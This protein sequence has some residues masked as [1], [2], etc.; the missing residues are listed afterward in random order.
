MKLSVIIPVRNRADH[1]NRALGALADQRGIAPTDVEVILSDD[2]STDAL[3]DVVARHRDRLDVRVVGPAV[4][5]GPFR[6]GAIRNRGL[7]A[8]KGDVAVLLDADVIPGPGFLRGHRDRHAERPGELVVLGTV[9]G[10][11]IDI[12]DRSPDRMNPPPADEL[13]DR[14][15]ELLMR[16]PALWTDGRLA[17]IAPWPG[18]E[19]CPFAWLWAWSYNMSFDR[20]I[21]ASIGNFDE[22]VPGPWGHEDTELAFRLERLGLQIRLEPKAW[23]VHTPHASRFVGDDLRLQLDYFTRKHPFPEVELFAWSAYDQERY[24]A[25]QAVRLV[26][27]ERERPSASDGAELALA[28]A[29]AG[30]NPSARVAWFGALPDGV[31]FRPAIHSRP[32][33]A[34]TLGGRHQGPALLGLFLPWPDRELDGAIVVD[35]WARLEELPLLSIVVEL[36]RIAQR[37]HLVGGDART[38]ARTVRW[39]ERA[40]AVVIATERGGGVLTTTAPP[41]GSP[42]RPLGR[43]NRTLR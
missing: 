11:P 28:L 25:C 18:L 33:E 17:L 8:A 40:G 32:Q 22:D 21:A 39:L 5:T 26:A 31:P 41:R 14:L 4:S 34:A 24:G 3:H 13:V 36:S 7:L 38:R 43:W 27:A 19:G 23:G 16:D 6:P 1:V 12:K 37:V 30:T 29:E 35:Y 9:A 10:Y 42:E 2:G 20:A 15:P